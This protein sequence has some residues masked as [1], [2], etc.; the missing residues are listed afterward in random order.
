MVGSRIDVEETVGNVDWNAK[1]AEDRGGRKGLH[2]V[3]G[4]AASSSLGQL[5][6]G[7]EPHR[8]PE[9]PRCTGV[10]GDQ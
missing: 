5:V 9:A 6:H 4:L 2:S 7:H 3:Q 1:S 8:V 10:D